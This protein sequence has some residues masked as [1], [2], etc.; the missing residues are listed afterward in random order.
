MPFHAPRL[1]QRLASSNRGQVIATTL[2]AALQGQIEEMIAEEA[3][4]I[5]DQSSVA[6]IVVENATREVK[7]Y[8][9]GADF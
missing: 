4:W 6:V 8:L 7:A 1:T 9:G 5:D 2:D 3:R